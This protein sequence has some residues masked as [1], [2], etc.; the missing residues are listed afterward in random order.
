MRTK[1]RSKSWKKKI[2]EWL[3]FW[4]CIVLVLIVLF[5]V[6]WELAASIKPPLKIMSTELIFFFRPTLD[7]WRFII[8]EGILHNMK[9]S[10]IVTSCAVLLTITFG[11]MGAYAFARFP[12][13]GKEFW[14]FQV[15]TLRMVPPIVPIIPLF[16]LMKQLKLLDTY[17]ALILTYTSMNLPFAIWI[18]TGFFK[19]V[20]TEVE[21]SARVDGCSWWNVYW[22]I[23]VPLS[24]PGLV[25]VAMLCA[26]FIWNEF[27]LGVIL[28]SSKV[29]TLAVRAAG[30]SPQFVSNWSNVAV[31]SVF[32]IFPLFIF[33]LIVQKYIVKGLTLGALK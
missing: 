10:I 24:I 11:S 3:F 30:V 28:T 32:T 9:N 31:I 2:K 6:L 29:Q 18:M 5:P 20:P 4:G 12:F 13:R 26:V 25:T 14:S 17:I 16:L 33:T 19:D 21:E 27:M 1:Y 15:L 7:N 22:K 8:E 23:T